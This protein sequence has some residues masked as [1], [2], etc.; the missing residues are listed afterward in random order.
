MVVVK[1]EL[2]RL[3]YKHDISLLNDKWQ[4]GKTGNLLVLEQDK[5]KEREARHALQACIAKVEETEALISNRKKK[6]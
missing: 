2:Q 4:R 1:E 6:R 3:R 5:R